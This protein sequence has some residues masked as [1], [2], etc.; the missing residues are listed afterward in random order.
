MRKNESISIDDIQLYIA[1]GIYL[2]PTLERRYVRMLI[3]LERKGKI[4]LLPITTL[5]LYNNKFNHK[6]I[7]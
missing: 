7:A 1:K 6:R 4:R 3:E 5:V 2:H